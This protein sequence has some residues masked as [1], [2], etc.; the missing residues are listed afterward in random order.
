[1][2]YWWGGVEGFNRTKPKSPY[3]SEPP[4]ICNSIRG[5]IRMTFFRVPIPFCPSPD[6][7]FHCPGDFQGRFRNAWRLTKCPISLLCQWKSRWRNVLTGKISHSMTLT[8][9]GQQNWKVQSWKGEPRKI[10]HFVNPPKGNPIYTDTRLLSPE[11]RA[12]APKVMSAR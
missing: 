8:Q 12:Q 11:W 9:M 2:G 3:I 1:M 6:M 4:L 10:C 7:S 5:G